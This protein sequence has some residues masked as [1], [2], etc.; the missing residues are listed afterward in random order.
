MSTLES[1]EQRARAYLRDYELWLQG[2]GASPSPTHGRDTASDV[3][4]LVEIAKIGWSVVEANYDTAGGDLIEKQPVWAAIDALHAA[5]T[6]L[7]APS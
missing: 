5:L 4:V 1:V 7:G 3:L 6:K 2:P